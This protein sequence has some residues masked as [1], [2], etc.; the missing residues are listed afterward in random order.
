[1]REKTTESCLVCGS[2]D[3]QEAIR[4]HDH[5]VS[6]KLFK[7]DE[8]GECG[9]RFISN[10]PPEHEA[11]Q[12]Y[13][14]DEYVEH[15]DSS[16]GLINWVYH[17]ARKWMLRYKYNLIN[18]MKRGQNILD[19]GTGTGYF[20]HFM[21]QK[22]YNVLG[23]EI[24]EK[25]RNFG[26]ERFGLTIKPPETVYKNGFAEGVNYVTFWHVLEHIYQPDKMMKRL[27]EIMDDKG[28]MVVALPNYRCLESGV[29]KSYWNG[30]DVPRHLW[31]WDKN[32]F[33]RF[34]RNC[35]FRL[36]K[37]RTL[38]LDP[39]YNCLISESYRKK[40]WAH[41]LIPF[42]G[43]ASLIMGWINKNKASSIVYFL[44]KAD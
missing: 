44:E 4:L 36:I 6:K 22:G 37:M 16:E 13:A 41:I 9:F 31:H 1:M 39:F 32:S 20:L 35:G 18:S 42:I 7:I 28:I 23:L 30:Y 19:I 29:Y 14:T 3:I 21:K 34:A 15:S 12:Y 25:A 11:G 43:A 38:P 26:I 17:R 33:E 40:N 5:L 8:C 10:P 24:S 2:V 27:H